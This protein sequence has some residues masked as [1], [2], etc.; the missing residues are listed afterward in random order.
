MS[1]ALDEIDTSEWLKREEVAKRLNISLP[2]LQRL[3]LKGKVNPVQVD[4]V[5]HYD[6]DEVEE[7]R[8]ELEK[9]RE[10]LERGPSKGSVD[11]YMYDTMKA[12]VNLVKDPREKID[13]I[14]FSIIEK[15]MAR[16]AD[17]E[18]QLESQR[19]AVETAK[20]QSL[21]RNMAMEMAKSEGRIKEIAAGRMVETI[22]KLMSG[23]GAPK[24]KFTPEQWEML[25]G[26]NKDGEEPFL[27]P[28]QVKVG[29]AAV[30]EAKKAK[31]GKAAVQAVAGAVKEKVQ[32][33]QG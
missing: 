2:K 7:V 15:L 12:I 26:A 10:L 29:E 31:N 9:E 28:E 32:S 5:N 11:A 23:F 24:I 20:D 3:Q 17:L 1:K 6:P 22:S 21:E 19:T 13:A 16:I 33:D 25:L 27:T 14:Q 4:H 8:Q 18:K 30:E